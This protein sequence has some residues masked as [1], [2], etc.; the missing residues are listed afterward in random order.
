MLSIMVDQSQLT[1]AVDM[2]MVGI[3][4]ATAKKRGTDRTGYSARSRVFGTT[5]RFPGSVVDALQDGENPVEMDHASRDPVLRR[6]AALRSAAQTALV[7]TD[8]DTRWQQAMSTGI[9]PKMRLR[10]WCA[11]VLLEGA[12][13]AT[14][15]ARKTCPHGCSLE[16]AG[17]SLRQ[18]SYDKGRRGGS[19]ELLGC[20]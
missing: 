6:A 16:W 8:A 9:R 11:S 17:D 2:R 7:K 12:E 13:G 19:A 15:I 14:S 4:A 18:E 5:E 10:A 1:R 3:L 20:L